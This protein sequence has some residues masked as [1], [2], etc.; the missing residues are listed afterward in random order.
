MKWCLDV[1]G[2]RA[3]EPAGQK[4]H[5]WCHA[6]CKIFIVILSFIESF[7]VQF[8]VVL[9]FNPLYK[10]SK[11][12]HNIFVF[13]NISSE[14]KKILEMQ[15]YHFRQALNNKTIPKNSLDITHAANTEAQQT[16]FPTQSSNCGA[17]SKTFVTEIVPFDWTRLKVLLHPKELV[18]NWCDQIE[19]QDR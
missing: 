8:H 19:S 16:V 10:V 18:W 14:Q 7:S 4:H 9:H 15:N 1:L 12:W 6:E 2:K 11:T 3:N 13:R 5:K 17:L